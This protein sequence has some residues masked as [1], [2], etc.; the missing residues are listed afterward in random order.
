MFNKQCAYLEEE[1]ERVERYV[2]DHSGSSDGE[3]IAQLNQCLKEI[4]NFINGSKNYSGVLGK[5]KNNMGSTPITLSCVLITNV[6]RG[7]SGIARR[8]LVHL[9][10]KLVHYLR[11]ST[12]AK[13]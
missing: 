4:K 12:R 11:T 7:K 9:C 8:Q 3:K 10:K 13:E 2:N 1:K 6:A 5:L